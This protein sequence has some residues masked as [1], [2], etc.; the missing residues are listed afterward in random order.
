MLK[1]V[2]D[3]SFAFKENLRGK[4]LGRLALTFTIAC[5][6]IRFRIFFHLLAC[7]LW[8]NGKHKNNSI[9]ESN[10]P[11]K[12]LNTYISCVAYL[13][14]IRRSKSLNAQKI[15]WIIL[16]FPIWRNIPKCTQNEKYIHYTHGILSAYPSAFSSGRSDVSPAFV[17]SWWTSWVN[18]LETSTLN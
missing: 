18:L 4:K 16:S 2:N 5:S 12:I 14:Q 17:A 3:R 15:R 9:V 1:K 13:N 6:I 11:I 7:L 8:T 10:L